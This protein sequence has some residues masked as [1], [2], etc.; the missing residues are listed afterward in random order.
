MRPLLKILAFPFILF[1]SFCQT[2]FSIFEALIAK[3][4]IFRM[5]KNTIEIGIVP[6]I[7]IIWLI[8]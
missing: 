8:S 7:L 6:L 3:P 1:W 2:L 4:F 5:E